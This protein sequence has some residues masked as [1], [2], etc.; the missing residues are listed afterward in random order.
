MPCGRKN[1]LI[2]KKEY[3]NKNT[4]FHP[5]GKQV[6]QD[7][8]EAQAVV[9]PFRGSPDRLMHPVFH[10]LMMKASIGE[11]VEG[12]YIQ[13]FLFQPLLNLL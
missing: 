7:I 12:K 4:S 8:K 3:F 11:A 2:G 1:N 10:H 6:N 5:F 13:A 9:K